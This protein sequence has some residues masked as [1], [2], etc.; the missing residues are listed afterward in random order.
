[1][2]IDIVF[3]LIMILA[4]FK[5]FS[6]GFIIG[7]FSFFAFIIGLAAALKLSTLVACYLETSTGSSGKWLPVLS[8]IIVFT[9]VVLVVNISARI[10]KKTISFAMLGWAD[11][12]GG[13]ILYMLIYTMIFSIILFFGEKTSLIS[14]ASIEKSSVFAYVAPW[15]PKIIDNFGKVIPLFKDMFNE[16]QNFF[17]NA[18]DRITSFL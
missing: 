17:E 9:L 3:Y 12:I 5:G 7:V 16:L 11:K 13:I 18:G 4:V 2:S 14:Q 1:M 8:F 6:K 10:L 15:G